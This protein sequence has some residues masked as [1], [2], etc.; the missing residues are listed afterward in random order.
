MSRAEIDPLE[1]M[2]IGAVVRQAA[3]LKIEVDAAATCCG[4]ACLWFRGPRSVALESQEAFELGSTVRISIP[5]HDVLLASAL[6]YG[7]PLG[8]LLLGGLGGSAF[9]DL[10]CLAGALGALAAAVVATPRRWLEARLSRH[11]QVRLPQ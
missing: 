4:G 10:G 6:L 11:L 3:P 2:S 7:V 8:A 5:K 1:R 9:G